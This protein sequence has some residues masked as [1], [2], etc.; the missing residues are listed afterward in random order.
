MGSGGNVSQIDEEVEA[1][2]WVVQESHR[3]ACFAGGPSLAWGPRGK[4]YWDWPY[5]VLFLELPI[6]EK[7]GSHF[8]RIPV[9]DRAAGPS[10]AAAASC[11]A[12]ATAA[13]AAAATLG[14]G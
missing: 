1:T 2:A 5:P 6:R 8:L 7:P 4:R 12:P 10:S 3:I 9:P 13:A 11:W 14:P